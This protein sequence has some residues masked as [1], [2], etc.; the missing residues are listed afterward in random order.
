MAHKKVK[1]GDEITAVILRSKGDRLK[2]K[3]FV[4]EIRMGY[5]RKTYL[6]TKGVV[7]DFPTRT[8]K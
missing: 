5:G 7:E 4:K 8:I 6:I 1:I 2:V 3:G